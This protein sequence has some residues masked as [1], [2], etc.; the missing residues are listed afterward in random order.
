[1]LQRVETAIA[2]RR[3]P[4]NLDEWHENLNTVPHVASGDEVSLARTK[5]EVL[6]DLAGDYGL[7]V[8]ASAATHGVWFTDATCTIPGAA[9][10][11]PLLEGSPV[12]TINLFRRTSQQPVP[13]QIS[14]AAVD[15]KFLAARNTWFLEEK[16]VALILRELR[17]CARDRKPGQGR[18]GALFVSPAAPSAREFIRY[19]SGVMAAVVGRATDELAQRLRLRPGM[20]HLRIEREGSLLRFAPEDGEATRPDDNSYYAD[21]FLLE[22]DGEKWCLF[23]RYDY[24]ERHG[25]IWAGRLEDDRVVEIRS[26]IDPGYH[27]S[28]PVPI[29]HGGE[30]F[31][32]PESCA[33]RR[34]EIWRCVSFPDQ[35][36]LHAT[37]LEDSMIADSALLELDGDWWIFANMA[38]DPFGDVSS[39]L[40]L[41]RTSGPDLAWVE[42]HRLNPVVF[43]SRMARNAGRI[44]RIGDAL[45]RPA[46]DNSHGTYG[47][48]LRIM[49]IETVG[50][51]EYRERSTRHVLP[52]FDPGVIGIH[53][54][55]RLGDQVIFDVRERMGGAA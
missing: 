22:R 48:G 35:W 27:L 34:L 55:D 7:T 20:F 8:P 2:A 1:M 32:M 47:Y 46:Q 30:L 49:K 52:D 17:R 42:P 50:R 14:S 38:S 19:L 29:E 28:F 36:E 39:E 51:D 44:H 9:G 40:H 31:V 43:D 24:A 5:P 12:S 10:L 4:A 21:P 26:A 3:P 18:E 15:G 45:Y 16:S 6:L 41:Y 23:E 25:S 37:A 11:R 53:H 33:M 54:V 13:S